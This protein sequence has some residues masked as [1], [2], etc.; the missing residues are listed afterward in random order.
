MKA[1]VWYMNWGR[2]WNVEENPIDARIGSSSLHRAGSGTW[3]SKN[4]IKGQSKKWRIEKWWMRSKDWKQTWIK[5]EQGLEFQ[6]GFAWSVT[7]HQ[8]P[9]TLYEGCTNSG[10]GRLGV[11]EVT[12]MDEPG[13]SLCTVLLK[14]SS[15]VFQSGTVKTAVGGM[16]VQ[17]IP[18]RREMEGLSEWEEL[19]LS[20]NLGGT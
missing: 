12:W 5:R 2:S 7:S 4:R 19:I 20:W 18:D 17:S 13:F 8:I 15:P 9:S 14:S 11:L 3:S 1:K 6:Y 16:E 10:S